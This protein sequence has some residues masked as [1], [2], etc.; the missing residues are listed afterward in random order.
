MK[1]IKS[2]LSNYDLSKFKV[3]YEQTL[4]PP[5]W[6]AL[7]VKR[8]PLCSCKLK[9]PLNKKIA[10]CRSKKHLK[11]FIIKVS[12]LNESPTIS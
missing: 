9:I 3:Y 1:T 8:C 12:K 5:N 10:F 4:F 2:L 11:P 6:E 7:K